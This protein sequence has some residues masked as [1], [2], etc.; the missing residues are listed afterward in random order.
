M[1]N[2]QLSM[3]MAQRVFLCSDLEKSD[4]LFFNSNPEENYDFTV[5][6][7]SLAENANIVHNLDVLE[8]E[9][10]NFQRYMPAIQ[11]KSYSWMK[12]LKQDIALM[13]P[14]CDW[15]HFFFR[16][17]KGMANLKQLP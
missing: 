15:I 8:N 1:P 7:H 13:T 2:V 3:K 5:K 12:C 9:V 16:S 14:L 17:G 6:Q 10:R 11:I 4:L